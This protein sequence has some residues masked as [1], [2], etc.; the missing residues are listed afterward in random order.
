MLNKNGESSTLINPKDISTLPALK[1][2]HPARSQTF[3]S[4]SEQFS[5]T[6]KILLDEF[7]K[8]V[9]TQAALFAGFTF[10]ILAFIDF[11]AAPDLSFWFGLCAV[12]TIALE[13]LAAVLSG[14]MVFLIKV[15]QV[16]KIPGAFKWQ[17]RTILASYLMG[18]VLF[19]VTVALL[20]LIKF[21]AIGFIAAVI[22]GIAFVIG[23]VLLVAALVAQPNC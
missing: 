17:N 15:E 20:V 19:V 22:L 13:L 10:G 6:D 7:L 2:F 14:A 5:A 1:Q 18:V 8:Q 12:T 23:A 3:M 16:E 21:P 11:N 9:G 4:E